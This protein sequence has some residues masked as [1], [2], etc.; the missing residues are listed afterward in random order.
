MAAK[1]NLNS[2]KM[3]V[4][5]MGL[6]LVGA[7]VLLGGLVWKKVG[8]DTSIAADCAGGHVNLKGHGMVVDSGFDGSTL[9]VT[10]EKKEGES[11]TMLIDICTGKITGSLT[12]DTDAAV[13]EE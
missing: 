9:R 6:V 12:L 8:S 4:F 11:E 3:L 10:F 5:S 13:V 1:E 7:I 2:I